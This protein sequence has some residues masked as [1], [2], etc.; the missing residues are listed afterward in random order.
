MKIEVVMFVI[1]VILFLISTLVIY[2]NTSGTKRK[3]LEVI[4]KKSL[5]IVGSTAVLSSILSIT[6]FAG[7]LDFGGY[8]LLSCWNTLYSV[9]VILFLLFRKKIPEKFKKLLN[10]SIHSLTICL[11][12]ELFVFNFN[13]THLFLGDYPEKTLDLSSAVTENFDLSSG[14]NVESGYSSIEFKG[15][16]TPVG[17]VSFDA[18][19]NK[20][21]YVD[22]SIDMSDDSHSASYRNGIASAEVIR[23]N[24]RSQ[25]IPCNFSGKVHDIKFSFNTDEGETITLKKITVN[26]PI[27]LDFSFTR[28]LVLFLGSL[29]I[30]LLAMSEFSRRSYD[31]NKRYV[32]AA[33]WI[34]T[35]A[36]VIP[37]LI[38]ANTS[39]YTDENHGIKKDFQSE[40]GNQITQEIVDAFADGR[41]S[42]DIEMNEAL[43]ALENPYDGSQREVGEIG[44]YPWDHLYFNGKYYSY[45]GIG[46]VLTLF[47]PYHLITGYYFP[48]IWAI[49]LFGIIGIIFLT[50][51]YLCFIEKFFKKINSSLAL[52]GCVIMQL[53]SGIWFCFNLSNFYEVAQTSGFVC[54]AVGAYF[55]MSSNVIGDGK[56]KNWRLA[57]STAFLS[58]AVLCRPTTAVYCIAALLLIFAGFKKKGELQSETKK[59]KGK[60]YLPYFL[61]ALVP[62]AAIGSIQVIYNYVR[63]KNPLDFGIQYSLTINDF[64]S[65]QFHT[66]FAAIG[67]FD[68]LFVIPKFQKDFPFFVSGDLQ[69]FDP[70]GYYFLATFS[71]IGLIW[72]AL[73]ILSYG[74][75][76][77][78]YR[79]SE[80]KNKKLYTLI[81]LAVCIVCPFAI[82]ASIWE[83]GYGSRY[84]VDFAWQI[85]IGALVIAFIVYQSC[86]KNTRE[87]LKK[88]MIVSMIVC[89]I[90]NFGQTF[91]WVSPKTALSPSWQAGALSFARLF[92]FW[93]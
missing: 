11:V 57:M 28:F 38:L 77:K 45:Y 55:M 21:G 71:A 92:E 60:Y 67:F 62:F 61:C 83:S 17:T 86:M 72:K 2:V 19:S 66:H 22:I 91:E 8:H 68:Y 47:L 33:V 49:F 50:K 70:Q 23:G 75:F 25:T 48:S 41:T 87:H 89:V 35:V 88:L 82:M 56:I 58:L 30:Y 73:P 6:D 16:N 46:P 54:V 74:K 5:T 7:L 36:L 37:A 1:S 9:I 65:S 85:I 20:K 43:E 84:C 80:N 69:T 27:M 13:S 93:R 42:L 81:I 39:R 53:S 12:L 14:N 32:K 52:M 15:L 40:S 78:A 31:E 51:F 3:I 64:T 63:F 26:K 44:S 4:R 79:L 34:F 90:L 29:I 76:R 24:E 10:F 59:S 18:V